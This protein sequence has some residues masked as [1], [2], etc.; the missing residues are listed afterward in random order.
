MRSTLIAVP[1]S[2]A[3]IIALAGT[4]QAGDLDAS[5]HLSR[6]VEGCIQT[7]PYFEQGR[8]YFQTVASNP[9]AAGEYLDEYVLPAALETKA[10]FIDIVYQGERSMQCLVEVAVPER[11]DD[12]PFETVARG[13]AGYVPKLAIKAEGC[14]AAS[15]AC[16]WEWQAGDD[17]Q[18]I[19]VARNV[20]GQV[21]AY[22][23]TH[24]YT[25]VG[26]YKDK[27]S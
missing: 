24:Y 2:V 27:G 10:Y 6:F 12:A 26:F 1:V 15:D 14:T 5:A 7:A 19:R 17:A 9:D 23:Y 4:P 3:G 21:P 18:V 13:V 11:L 16:Q 8:G 20:A 22:F 25:T